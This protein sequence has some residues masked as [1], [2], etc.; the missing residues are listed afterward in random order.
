MKSR[1]LSGALIATMLL[2]LVVACRPPAAPAAAL[3][4]ATPGQAAAGEQP[5]APTPTPQPPTSTPLPT[6]T[7]KPEPSPTPVDPGADFT[8]AS[9]ASQGIAEP[10]LDKLVQIVS[11]YVEDDKVVGSELMVLKN[12]RIVL[13]E[14]FGWLD[15]DEASAMSVNTLFNIRSMTKPVVA[16]AIL[17]LVDDG[18]LSLD[19]PVAAYLPAFENEASGKIT[20]RQL[21]THRS[22]LP[23]T[24][25][26]GGL[27]EI[28]SLREIADGAGEQGPDTE[29]GSGFQYSDTGYE[30]LGALVEAISGMPLGQFLHARILEPLQMHE[31]LTLIRAGDPLT[32]RIA[33]LYYGG[34]GTWQRFWGRQDEPFYAFTMGSQSIYSTPLDYARF[35]A[36]W[37]DEG[38]ANGEQRLSPDL[39][40]EALVPVS[41][42]KLPGAFPSLRLDY[43]QGW[44]LYVPEDAPQGEGEVALF[45]HSGSDGTWA[46]AWPDRDLIVLYFTQSRGQGTGITLEDELDRLLIHPD[47]EEVAVDASL[48]LYLGSYT[49]LSGPLMYKT[50]EIL[51]Q[52]GR[53]AVN[54]PE[55][56]VIALESPDDEGLWHLTLDPSLA[57][58]FVEDEMGTVTA[59]RW[60]QGGQTYEVPRGMAP[61]EPP[62]DTE[63]VE[64]YLGT[65]ERTEQDDTIEV[66]IH[67]GHLSLQAPDIPIPLELFPPDEAGLWRL[68]ANPEIAIDFQEDEQGTGV[69]LTVHAPNETVVHPRVD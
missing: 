36:L 58:S 44:V 51:V 17:M 33:S 64:G 27:G 14:A 22:G 54:M 31:T 21:L 52:N 6:A 28:A 66:I 67:N 69:S 4:T 7:A 42:T 32:D 39:V 35:L 16:T 49:A 61:E 29:P 57:I 13:H 1:I 24:T 41:D 62:L 5:V 19:D 56:I 38:R 18:D 11:G 60:H 68:R 65:Y 40:R 45:G 2:P 3:P 23:L 63:A 10:A 50:F 37:M 9:P 12:R 20:V 15:R 47:R 46:W 8:Y 30:V 26:G 55:Q 48:E 59:L 53:L 43:G 25:V 34:Q